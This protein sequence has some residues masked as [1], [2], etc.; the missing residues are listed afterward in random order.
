[1]TVSL[2]RRRIYVEGPA[3]TRIL[4]HWFPHLD[5]VEA[6]GKDQVRLQVTRDPISYGL[7]DRDFAT[8]EMVAASRAAG[9]RLAIMERYAIENY[10]LESAIIM[11]VAGQLDEAHHSADQRR[12]WGEQ[13]DV[14]HEIQRWAGELAIYAAA[15]S[16]IYEWRE[17]IEAGF[18]RYFR[19]LPPK[20]R[21]QVLANLRQ[22]LSA[23]PAAAQ[24]EIIFGERYNQVMADIAEWD[25]LHRW[26]HGKVLLEEYLFPR[27]RIHNLSQ[28]RLRDMLTEA[29]RQRVPP[30]LV[31]LASQWSRAD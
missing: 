28:A 1:M 22:I 9:S 10:L 8:E 29:G 3:D 20:S 11:A 7:L 2:A 13:T 14:E 17:R 23:L 30:E 19:E 5:L 12:S 26:I 15:N 18:L 24:I 6:G 16:V 31:E 4:R 27:L 25:G 21:D